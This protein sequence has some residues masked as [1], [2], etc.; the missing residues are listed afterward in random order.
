MQSFRS[1]F[2]RLVAEGRSDREI[3][4]IMR[5]DLQTARRHMEEGRQAIAL[6]EDQIQQ[7]SDICLHS[8]LSPIM[9]Q[10]PT[11]P[12]RDGRPPKRQARWGAW[13]DVALGIKQAA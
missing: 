1:P 8:A 12:G 5:C 9:V 11:R 7:A 10:F 4:T 13:P 3:A 6:H 2:T